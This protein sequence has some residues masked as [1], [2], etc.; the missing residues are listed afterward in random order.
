[1]TKEQGGVPKWFEAMVKYQAK[2][3]HGLDP[4]KHDLVE[5]YE[6]MDA[7]GA[8]R[9]VTCARCGERW[10]ITPRLDGFMLQV[11]FRCRCGVIEGSPSDLWESI[12]QTAEDELPNQYRALAKV[13]P[14]GLEER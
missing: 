5:L 9:K 4:T 6:R 8:K 2:V 3:D 12:V 1:M 14:N 11:S 10:V 13:K 7:E